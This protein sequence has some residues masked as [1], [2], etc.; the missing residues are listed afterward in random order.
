MKIIK[1]EVEDGGTDDVTFYIILDKKTQQIP[2]K[3]KD[4]YFFP[5]KSKENQ[6]QDLVS[7]I[8]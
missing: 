2:Q 6:L 8:Q 5:S 7:N 1:K 3:L 4:F